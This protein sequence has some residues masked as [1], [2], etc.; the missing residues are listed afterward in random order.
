MDEWMDE[1]MCVCAHVLRFAF[2]ARRE[3]GMGDA[4]EQLTSQLMVQPVG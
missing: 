1:W 2:S 3:Q 4:L